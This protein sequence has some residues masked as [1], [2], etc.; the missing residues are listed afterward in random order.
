MG[1]DGQRRQIIRDHEKILG[2]D[3]KYVYYLVYDGGFIDVHMSE[4]QQTIHYKMCHLY[5]SIVL[6]YCYKN[7]N[8]QM[9]KMFK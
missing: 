5:T 4:A 8:R 9:K 3:N 2:D 6:Q 1:R 7:I